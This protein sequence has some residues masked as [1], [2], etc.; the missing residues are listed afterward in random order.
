MPHVPQRRD[1]RARGASS[2]AVHHAC[3]QF[4]DAVLVWNPAI[5][6]AVLL[7]IVLDQRHPF[8]TSL[9]WRHAGQ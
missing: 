9:Q 8:D 6:D 3:I 5:A 7:G 2:P 4:D 1:A